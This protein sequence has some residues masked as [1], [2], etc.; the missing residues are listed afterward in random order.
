MG[1]LLLDLGALGWRLSLR[2]SHDFAAVKTIQKARK[3]LLRNTCDA[4]VWLK[5]AAAIVALEGHTHTTLDARRTFLART[6]SLDVD[7]R[8]I[9]HCRYN[10]SVFLAF[11]CEN[12][13]GDHF[14]IHW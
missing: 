13:L 1:I 5:M 12:R 7:V 11:C 2:R 14:P 3:V 4:F 6:D 10:K 9:A 8:R